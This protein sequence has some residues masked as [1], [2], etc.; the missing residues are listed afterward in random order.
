MVTVQHQKARTTPWTT[1]ERL[2][3]LFKKTPMN[4]LNIMQLL[5]LPQ[6]NKE[7]DKH[8]LVD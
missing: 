4:V 7:V 5:H 1:N 2:S 3:A 8:A 6:E